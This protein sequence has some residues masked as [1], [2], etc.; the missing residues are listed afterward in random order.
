MLLNQSF[1]WSDQ[2]ASVYAGSNYVV[3]SVTAWSYTV[4]LGIKTRLLFESC[5]DVPYKSKYVLE[6]RKSSI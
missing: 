6:N 1:P 5:I 2:F 4:F 3:L